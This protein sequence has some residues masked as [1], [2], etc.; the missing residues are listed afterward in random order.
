MLTIVSRHH[1]VRDAA[2]EAAAIAPRGAQSSS[3]LY[4]RATG[5]FRELADEVIAIQ[6][7]LDPTRGTYEHDECHNAIHILTRIWQLRSDAHRLTIASRQTDF[8]RAMAKRAADKAQKLV[9]LSRRR[10][11]GIDAWTE[12]HD[13]LVRMTGADLTM[14]P[15]F[16]RYALVTVAPTGSI[17]TISPT[18]GTWR[19]GQG[20]T[21]RGT[22]EQFEVWWRRRYGCPPAAH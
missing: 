13:R 20:S 4:S 3:E 21:Y 2:D 7:T 22:P 9:T 1:P 8:S 14:V 16:G 10:A 12:A 17:V 18:L 15:A 5:V 6:S 11:D 19:V